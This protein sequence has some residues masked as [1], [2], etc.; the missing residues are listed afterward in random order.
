[1]KTP[2]LHIDTASPIP[3]YRQ[4]VDQLR[5]LFIEQTLAPGATLPPV[6]RL[7]LELGLHFNTVAQA[8]RALADEGFLE[9]KHGRGAIVLDRVAPP[10]ARQAKQAAVR[11]LRQRLREL[12]AERRAS[13]LT[14]KQIAIEL[15]DLL[16]SLES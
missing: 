6:R 3:A 12:V 4:I 9:I 11:T 15:R 8:Y 10:P 13:G 7:A 14:Q 5:A 1:M 16:G 2:S